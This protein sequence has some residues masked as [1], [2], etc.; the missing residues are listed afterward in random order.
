MLA[1]GIKDIWCATMYVPDNTPH[2]PHDFRARYRRCSRELG[3]L[4]LSLLILILLAAL[5]I[6]IFFL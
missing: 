4:G 2:S 6:V 3:R 5:I 1:V